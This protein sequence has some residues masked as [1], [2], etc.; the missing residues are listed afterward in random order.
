MIIKRLALGS[1]IAGG[2]FVIGCAPTTLDQNWR[3]SLETARYNQT[4]NPAA[5]KNLAPVTGL[6]G[7]SAANAVETYRKSFAGGEQRPPQ[8][9]KVPGIGMKP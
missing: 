9:V 2:I 7:Q 1:I 3:R 8:D 4:L 6:D 5:E